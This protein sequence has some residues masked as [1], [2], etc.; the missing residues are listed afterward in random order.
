M[1]I[2]GFQNINKAEFKINKLSQENP[3]ALIEFYRMHYEDFFTINGDFEDEIVIPVFE[4]KMIYL[5]LIKIY[6]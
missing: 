3:T 5:E 2:L 4:V 1:I 6:L